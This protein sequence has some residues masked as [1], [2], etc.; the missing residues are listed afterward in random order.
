MFVYPCTMNICVCAAE[1][2]EGALDPLELGPEMAVIRLRGH[3]ALNSSSLQQA[4]TVANRFHRPCS[5]F[6]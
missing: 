3:S 5:Y 1:G 2:A 6:K 4:L